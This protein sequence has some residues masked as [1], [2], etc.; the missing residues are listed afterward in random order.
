MANNYPQI[1]IASPLSRQVQD[2]IYFNYF[3]LIQIYCF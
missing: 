1:I 3:R 2:L